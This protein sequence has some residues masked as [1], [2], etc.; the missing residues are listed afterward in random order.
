MVCRDYSVTVD[1]THL[2]CVPLKTQNMHVID[3]IDAGFFFII[4]CARVA[5][6][7]YTIVRDPSAEQKETNLN[8]R[9]GEQGLH[10]GPEPHLSNL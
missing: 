6:R 2:T 7:Q 5:F 10:L 3:R 4:W 8:S 9:Y 1:M